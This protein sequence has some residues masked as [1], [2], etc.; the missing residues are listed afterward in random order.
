MAAAQL[1]STCFLP[2]FEGLRSSTSKVP[3]VVVSLPF[4]SLT[5]RYTRG[6]VVKS[7]TTVAPK[8]T[9]L[10]PLGDRVLVKIK[11]AE[12]KTVGGILLPSTAQTKPQGGEVV[13]VGEGRTIG[14]KKVDIGVQ[15]GTPIVYSKYAGTEVE[16]NGLSNLILKEDDIVGIL[17]TDDVK[18][19]KPLNDRVLIKVEE[20]EETTAG[21][22][23]LTQAT[24][25]KPSIG[26]V[27]AVGPGPLNEEGNRT[28]LPLSPGN[29]VL[30]SKFAG[31]DFKGADGSDY[32]TLCASDVMAVLS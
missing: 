5:L 3:S 32:I 24:K 25:E 30:Y 1:T 16:F 21:G 2:S 13:A 14:D 11:A 15:T 26:T 7:A 19:L 31:N 28:G 23:L 10:K 17:E 9:S 6:L 29:T 20:A 18:D 22:L 27:I 8:Y 12:E 4:R